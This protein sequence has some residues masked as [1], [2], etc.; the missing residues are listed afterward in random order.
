MKRVKTE[1]KLKLNRESL[2]NLNSDDLTQVQ[3]ASGAIACLSR[4][5]KSLFCS[6]TGAY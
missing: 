5:C 4:V 6:P 2:R 3:G 1:K